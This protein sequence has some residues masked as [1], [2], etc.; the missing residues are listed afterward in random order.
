[1]KRI[2]LFLFLFTFSSNYSNAQLPYPYEE[3]MEW[4]YD[5][6][7]FWESN[8]DYNH[9]YING[10][11]TILGKDCQI[12]HR[13]YMSCESRPLK[14]YFYKENSKIYYYD[15]PV[16]EFKRLYDFDLGVGDIDTIQYW[17]EMATPELSHFYCRVDSLDT[18][19]YNSIELKRFHVTY[20]FL[21]RPSSTPF[22]TWSA[23][24]GVIVEDI[25]GLA[26]YFHA[27][28]AFSFP[29]DWQYTRGLRCFNT[30]S[31]GLLQYDNLGCDYVSAKSP[32]Q[33]EKQLSLFPNPSNNIINIQGDW[34]NEN[35]RIN[36][37]DI[38]GKLIFQKEINSYGNNINEELN[39]SDFPNGIYFI[40]I[41]SDTQTFKEK[42]IKM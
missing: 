22:T 28:D 7:E 33:Q 15:A 12:M 42:I 8:L 10:D 36:L 1:M 18:I 5:F 11:T 20:E 13:R 35:N 38:S 3:G 26:N 39:I 6:Y 4:Y 27:D 9:F 2:L 41:K 30:Y 14:E 32:L 40:E 29:C 17:S 25:G 23:R 19:L 37:F 34:E 21:P 24:E 31:Y 16:S